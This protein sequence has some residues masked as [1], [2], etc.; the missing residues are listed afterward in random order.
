MPI[1]P[2]GSRP[3]YGVDAPG[4]PIGLGAAALCCAVATVLL[5]RRG[6]W[7]V[8][9]GAL[10]L[11]GVSLAVTLA[12]YLHTTL[13]G[14]FGVWDDELDRLALRGD[15]T[16]V[17]LGCG[18]G[19]VLLAAASRL[20]RGTAIG[21][22]LWRPVDQS[23]NSADATRANA[24]ALGLTDRVE[25]R[26]ADLAE[27]PL[28]DASADVVVSSLV[29]HNIHDRER[30]DAAL[31]GAARV[32][33][34]GGRLVLA[35]LAH[36]PQYSDTLAGAG[37][38][39]VRHRR[40]DWRFWWAGP[41]GA[42]ILTASR[43]HLPALAEPDGKGDSGTD[44]RYRSSCASSSPAPAGRVTSPRCSRSPRR[45]GGRVTRRC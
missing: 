31:R 19:A 1:P 20:P 14:K 23:G 13:R 5:P 41:F 34:P 29:L 45:A 37:L 38:V 30:R 15:E 4:A 39:G 17:D 42:R 10:A 44:R 35:D 6:R 40:A 16:V 28:P 21:V 27:L 11:S 3:S 9:R 22:D 18:R 24:A 26:T 12:E 32:L 2:S 25:L 43:P 36:V 33:R 7:Q 8:L